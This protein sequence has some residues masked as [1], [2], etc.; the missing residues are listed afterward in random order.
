MAEDEPTESRTAKVGPVRDVW[1]WV[2][3]VQQ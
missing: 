1:V 2:V 3:S